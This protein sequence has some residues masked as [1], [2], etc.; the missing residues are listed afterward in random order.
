[1]SRYKVSHPNQP[2][3]VRA[4]LRLYEFL[5]SLKLAVVLI[6]SLAA[7]LAFATFVES[8]LGTKAAQWYV[9]H[10]R[11]FAF[12]LILL[13]V[14]IFCAA[15]IR[16]PWK[17]HQTGFV[18]THI[19]L[20]TL[21]AGSAVSF[22]SSVNS[23]MLVYL[24]D[25]SQHA[26]DS[27]AGGYL[28][29]QHIPGHPEP[30]H[31]RLSPGPFN[32]NSPNDTPYPMTR[33]VMSLFGMD[34]ASKPWQ[35]PPEVIFDDGKTKVEVIDFLSRS[36]VRRV[37]YLG[38]KFRQSKLNFEIPVDLEFDAENK[39][40]LA[41]FQGMGSVLMWQAEDGNSLRPFA[42]CIPQRT[43]DGD[44]AVVVWWKGEAHHFPVAQLEQRK[45]DGLPYDLGDGL[46]IEL[47]TYAPAA[48]LRTTME[49][50]KLVSRGTE[51]TMP[52]V[53]VK[54]KFKAGDKE[55][56]FSVIR[57]ARLPLNRREKLPEGL[58]IEFYH[59]V[60][61]PRIDILQGPDEQ[62]AYRAWQQKTGR[63]VS[64][65]PLQ[66]GDEVD[67][68]SMGGGEAVWKM[69]LEHYVTPAS[70]TERFRVI[71]LPFDKADTGDTKRVKIRVTTTG[72]DGKS[73]ADE[74]W[75]KQNLPEPWVPPNTDQI[76][77]TQSSTGKP[78][79]S[80]YHVH[81]TD[82][83]FAFKLVEF[84]LDVDPGTRTAANYTSHLAQVDVRDKPEI[85]ALEQQIT[86]ASDAQQRQDLREQLADTRKS[87][88]SERL[89]KLESATSLDAIEKLSAEDPAIQLHLITMNRPLDYPDLQGRHLRFFQE[90]Y[91]PP[92]DA[93]RRPLGS[94]FRVNYDPGRP[95][96]YLGSALIVF[97]I[98]LM[99]YMRA[100]FF[101]K[102]APAEVPTEFSQ[103]KKSNREP[104][105]VG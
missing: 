89:T 41:D 95:I 73:A 53:S 100:Y 51:P 2:F 20:L 30:V 77:E 34:D 57:M 17:R 9:Y 5:A 3:P 98:F 48:D 76:H 44:G 104:L 7:V 101:K 16:F 22:K 46:T 84:D 40:A 32:W 94:V 27:D 47:D 97:G 4:L 10:S 11:A 38:L 99:F 1:M 60:A 67:T 63:V 19:G 33:R 13:A 83:G 58:W 92:N 14:N 79:L 42:E 65:G 70:P 59:P 36:D 71:P 88:I 93:A 18:I 45:K 52:A 96:K 78:I 6:F 72:T 61:G 31:Y 29:F 35:H 74:F 39:F 56:E 91:V 86:D 49:T 105:P 90:N 80:S 43:V 50:G 8:N 26:I 21:L 25:A 15:A 102:P 81:E 103:P 66:L 87:M 64:S 82:V 62:L 55:E 28:T 12:L 69:G 54:A 37:P 68:W 85:L 75:L 23:Q 24:N